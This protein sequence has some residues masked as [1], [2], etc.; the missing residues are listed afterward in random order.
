M[1]RG[2]VFFEIEKIEQLALINRLTTHH[3]SRPSL[4]S[5]RRRNHDSPISARTFSTASV[6]LR[7]RD[8]AMAR[9][10]CLQQRTCL[11][12]AGTVVE[13]PQA[14]SCSAAKS[15]LYSTQPA[16]ER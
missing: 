15:R 9:P 3:D 12:S 16:A 8:S 7:S 10:V 6:K 5:F 4:K 14:D 2:N 1:I 11:V 13:C